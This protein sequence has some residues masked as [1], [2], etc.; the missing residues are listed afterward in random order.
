MKKSTSMIVS[1]AMVLS[2]SLNIAAM[3]QSKGPVQSFI[4]ALEVGEPIYYENL[5][6]VPIYSTQIKDRTAYYALDEALANNWISINELEGGQVPQVMISNNSNKYIYIMGGEILTGCKQDR[7]VGRD[8]L[9]KPKSKNVIVPVYCVE[10][11]RWNYES[12]KF[13]SKSNLGTHELRSAAQKGAPEAQS[14][15]WGKVAGYSRRLSVSSETGN[16]QDI[17]EDEAVA[18]KCSVIENHIKDIPNLNR[19]TVG[20]AVGL[21]SRIV[22]V[23][24]FANPELFR[25]LWP[26]IARSS[27]LSSVSESANGTITQNMAAAFLRDLHAKTYQHKTA[28][29]LGYELTVSDNQVNANA[30]VYNGVIHLAAFTPKPDYQSVDDHYKSTDPNHERRIPVIRR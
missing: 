26:K 1:L 28:I 25:K 10:Q 15:I 13:Y 4:E 14:S 12:E 18:Q 27:A 16:Y 11:G 8:V 19:D 30:L 9:I 24:I 5:T 21:G 17:F 7:I 6:I 23:D 29:D 3:A 2:L 22:S 20:I